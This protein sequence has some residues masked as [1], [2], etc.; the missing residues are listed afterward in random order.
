MISLTSDQTSRL[1][2]LITQLREQN[3][4]LESRVKELENEIARLKK[5]NPQPDI[6]ANRPPKTD[7][8]PEDSSQSVDDDE[9]QNTPKSEVNRP[10]ESTPRHR[11]QPARP[12]VTEVQRIAPDVIPEGSVRNGYSPFFVQELE[13][14]AKTIRYQ[15]E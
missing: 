5:L 7:E 15:L 1:L 13:M 12:P 14:Q 9:V 3:A 4:K 10:K 11:T 6:K 2:E 8:K